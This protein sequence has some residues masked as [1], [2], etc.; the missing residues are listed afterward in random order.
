MK[1][2]L[3]ILVTTL[4]LNAILLTQE[5]SKVGTTAAGFLNIDVGAR[6]IGMGSSFTTVVSDISSMY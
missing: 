5:V 3:I 6:A 1:K 4:L 2:L